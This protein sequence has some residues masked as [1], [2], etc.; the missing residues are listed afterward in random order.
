VEPDEKA[1]PFC[2]ETIKTAAIKCKHCG[3]MLDDDV[4]PVESLTC[5][6][7]GEVRSTEQSLYDHR[8]AMHAYVDYRGGPSGR[9]P[10]T[11]RYS[12]RMGERRR[13]SAVGA[14]TEGGI[15]C[16]RCGG[17]QFTAKRSNTGKAVGFATLGVGGLIAPK[18]Q[19][20]CVTCG[21]KFKRG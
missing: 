21:M 16:P 5:P 20:K 14:K 1:C 15:A 10:S 17:T 8:V 18:S 13:L 19:V 2:A 12:G 3:E 4:E 11:A 6:S 7:C 9:G